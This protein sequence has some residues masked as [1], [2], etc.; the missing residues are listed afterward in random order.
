[1]KEIIFDKN[2]YSSYKDFYSQIYKDL[3]GEKIP[4]W[5]DYKDL[6]YNADGLNEFLWYCHND[7]IKYIFVNFDKEKIK[8]QKTYD[9]YEYNLVL[10]VFEEFVEKYPNNKL[11]FRMDEDKK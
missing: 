7:N 8:L 5:E 10:E 2:K 6:C 4:D 3:E 1:M 11:E 9:D